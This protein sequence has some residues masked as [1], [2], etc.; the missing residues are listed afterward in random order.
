MIAITYQ[1]P[2]ALRLDRVPDPALRAPGD[3]IVRVRAAGICGSDLHV[4]HGREVGLDHGTVMGHEAVGEVVEG[5]AAVRMHQHGD[6]VLC[7]FTTACGHCFF[8]RHGLTARCTRGQLFGWVQGGNGLDG[9]Q[10]QQMRVP[11][12]DSTLVPVP[13]DLTPETALLLCD[14]IPTG[15]YCAPRAELGRDDTVLVLGCGPVGLAAILAARDFGAARV[16]AVDPIPE[17]LALAARFGATALHAERTDVHAAI[18]DL[19]DGRGVDAVLEAVGSPT[20]SRLAFQWVR[21]GGVISVVGVHHEEH[22]AFSPGEA[23]DKNLTVR[24][25]RCPVRPPP[26]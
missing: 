20:A 22:F 4:V 5:G 15:A 18:R 21:P 26:D 13:K 24:G 6:L 1:G 3:A 9:A 25:G 8:C 17:R 14:V 11:L 7:P 12:A 16:L 10:A 19:T 23:Y 2:R